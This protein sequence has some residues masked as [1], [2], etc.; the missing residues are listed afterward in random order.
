MIRRR[1][2]DGRDLLD[3]RGAER[4]K[5]LERQVQFFAAE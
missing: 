1:P 3:G 4:R 2:L 5:I